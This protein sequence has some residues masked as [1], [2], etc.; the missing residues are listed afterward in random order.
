[1]DLSE[2]EARLVVIESSRPARLHSET[3]SRKYN[4]IQKVLA[5][6]LDAEFRFVCLPLQTTLRLWKQWRRA[7]PGWALS[8]HLKLLA[9]LC[10][11]DA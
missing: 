4:T 2:F 8:R 9:T 6:T 5:S 3:L 10:V 7:S 11:N 1:M